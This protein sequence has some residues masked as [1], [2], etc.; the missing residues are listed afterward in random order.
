MSYL[1]KLGK[2]WNVSKSGFIVVQADSKNIPKLGLDVVN[3][4][5]NKVGYIYDII[6]PVKTPFI[7]VKP[8]EGVLEKS[9]PDELF[10]VKA[11]GRGGEGG[12]KKRSREGGRKKRS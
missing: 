2:V 4:K 11:Y 3:R 12:R 1:R 5:M 8:Y 7:L 9:I 6:G 10:V